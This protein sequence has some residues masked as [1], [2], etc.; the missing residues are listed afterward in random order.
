MEMSKAEYA[1]HAGLT[2]GRISQLTTKGALLS[3]AVTESGK[4]DAALADRLRGK[5]YDPSNNMAKAAPAPDVAEGGL[6]PNAEKLAAEEELLELRRRSAAVKAQNDE[7]NLEERKGTLVH[8]ERLKGTLED[9]LK[10]LFM[11]LRS[12]KQEMVDALIGAGLVAPE[13]RA[14]ALTILGEG[15]EKVIEEFRRGL[16]SGTTDA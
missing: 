3:R 13:G 16:A 1:R 10:V 15:A 8:R 9:R 4:I 6:K 5:S 12:S 7:L 2:P 11:N 14:Q